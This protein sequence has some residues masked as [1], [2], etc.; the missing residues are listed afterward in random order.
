MNNNSNK[1]DTLIFWFRTP[2]KVS[3][4]AFNFV[5]TNW[6]QKVIYVID[7]D[8]PEYRKATNWND[9]D[10]GN[11]EVI[12]LDGLKNENEVITQIFDNYPNAIHIVS[13]F[14]NSIQWVI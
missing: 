14:T 3:K 13:A 1:R 4:G 2:P 12:M 11:A 9:G 6:G 7:K 8:F 5:S 10:F